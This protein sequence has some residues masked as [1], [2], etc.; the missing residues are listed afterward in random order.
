VGRRGSV[1]TLDPG[2]EDADSIAFTPD[3]RTLAAT[4]ATLTLWDVSCRIVS[5]Q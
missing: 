3:G 1:S 4:G 2:Q 5:R